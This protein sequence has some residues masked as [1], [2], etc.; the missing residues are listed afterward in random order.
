MEAVDRCSRR[1]SKREVDG[2][3]RRSMAGAPERRRSSGDHEERG[4]VLPGAE[5]QP[6]GAVRLRVILHQADTDLC[7]QLGVEATAPPQIPEHD[8]HVVEHPCAS[9]DQRVIDLP[10][11]ARAALSNL[12]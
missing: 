1:R 7:Q 2:A 6:A 10:R 8:A 4:L 9:Y 3:H 11:F 5:H 12:R